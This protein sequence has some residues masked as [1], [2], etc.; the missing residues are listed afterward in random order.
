MEL[1]IGGLGVL[2]SIVLDIYK[3]CFSRIYIWSPR[4]YVDQ[5]RK[6]VKDYSRDHI[7]PND[8]ENTYFD[9]YD[10]SGL[11]AIITTQQ[12]VID[13]NKHKEIYQILI[14]I[15]DF[16]G[17]PDFARK[18]TLRHQLY[19]RG[20]HY[21]ISTITSTHVYKQ[22]SLIVRSS[23]TNSFIYRLRSYGELGPIIEEMSAI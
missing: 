18:S 11:Q 9:E 15:D 19:L 20:R 4:V 2:T 5:T 10:P 21:M 23:I 22:T 1:L 17:S 16:A 6:P 12:K 7:K 13:Y 14:C 8:R 3:G